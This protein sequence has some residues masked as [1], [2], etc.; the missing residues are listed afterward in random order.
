MRGQIKRKDSSLA[1]FFFC[2]FIF[3]SF[4][5][6][7]FGRGG[8]GGG[9]RSHPSHHPPAY[10]PVYHSAT[11]YHCR[12]DQQGSLRLGKLREHS[13]S[14]KSTRLRL[15]PLE[16]FSRALRTSRV[17]PLLDR[18]TLLVEHWSVVWQFVASDQPEAVAIFKYPLTKTHHQKEN[19]KITSNHA[20][21]D[22]LIFLPRILFF[23]PIHHFEKTSRPSLTR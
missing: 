21:N 3:G 13:R 1:F 18:R 22:Q 10:A 16:R 5:A 9:M 19:T 4:Q 7:L 23:L 8:G 17:H 14:W 20:R 6:D 15:V 11:E 12:F 2:K